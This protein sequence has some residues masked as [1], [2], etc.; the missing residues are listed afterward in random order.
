MTEVRMRSRRGV[1]VVAVLLTACGYVRSGQWEDAPENWSRAFGSSKSRGAEIVH[2]YYW[3]APHFTYEA[4]Y[5]FAIRDAGGFKT[6]L[7]SRNKL[8]MV[9]EEQAARARETLFGTVPSWFVPKEPHRYEVW[10]F[11]DEPRSN[12][13]V[14]VDK[15]DG[16]LFLADYQV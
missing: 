8:R 7:F 14:F 13:R 2:S 1:L 6:E 10:V 5:F 16:T 11:E 3:R 9:S 4:G 15:D 12:F